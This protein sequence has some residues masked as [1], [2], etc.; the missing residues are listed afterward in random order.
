MLGIDNVLLA[1]GLGPGSG[2]LRP[3]LGADREVRLPPQAGIVGYRLGDE[4]PGLLL[5]HDPTLAPSPPRRSPRV[6]FEVPDARAAAEGL[7]DRGVLPVE[8]VRQLRTG[9]VVEVADPWGN[10]VGLT[11]YLLA[12]ERA[13]PPGSTTG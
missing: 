12:P 7:S 6:W 10:V 5:R 4:D 2:L 3:G 9:W 13:R 1:V 11:D 8:P